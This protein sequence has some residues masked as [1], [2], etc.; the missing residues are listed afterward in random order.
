[1]V[2]KNNRNLFSHSSGRQSK[3]QNVNRAILLLK[4]RGKNSYFISFWWL[5]AFLDCGSITL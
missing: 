2:A 4:A 1:M 5:M 3:N